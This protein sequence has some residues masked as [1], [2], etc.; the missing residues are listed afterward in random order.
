MDLSIRNNDDGNDTNF[1]KYSAIGN[2]KA[3]PTRL[4]NFDKGYVEPKKESTSKP[5]L[6]K[7]EP[8]TKPSEAKKSTG[9]QGMLDKQTSNAPIKASENKVASKDT[10]STAK[11]KPGSKKTS[12]KGNNQMVSE[13]F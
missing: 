1:S 7:K 10:T 13:K 8:P 2:K 3:V 12:A 6:P 5:D 9:I 4:P 11:Q